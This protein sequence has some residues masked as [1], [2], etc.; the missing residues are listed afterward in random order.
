MDDAARAAAEV[1]R[2]PAF[3]EAALYGE[4]FR[5]PAERDRIRSSLQGGAVIY[6]YHAPPAGW[7]WRTRFASVA[8]AG[9]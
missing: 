9:A 4:V 7:P 2:R 6:R 5:D 3:F 8:T 1:H